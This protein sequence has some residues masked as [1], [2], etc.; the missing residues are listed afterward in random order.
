[1]S[2]TGTIIYTT[3]IEHNKLAEDRGKVQQ[4]MDYL[5]T[6]HLDKI[7]PLVQ[8]LK[9]S[10][11]MDYYNRRFMARCF[12]RGD[13]KLAARRLSRILMSTFDPNSYPSFIRCLH[14]LD[15]SYVVDMF[16]K[17]NIGEHVD[18]T[19]KGP[20]L[21]RVPESD[22]KKQEKESSMA[23]SDNSSQTGSLPD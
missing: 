7:K 1:M 8:L 23:S 16:D 6:H 22:L 12:D 20:D 19:E 2:A 5:V 9:G 10:S 13:I 4:I 11:D 17:G 21:W 14:K 18:N 3:G 15:L